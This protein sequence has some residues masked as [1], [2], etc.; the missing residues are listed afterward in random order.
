MQ[1]GGELSPRHRLNIL[2][3]ALIMNKNII[4]TTIAF[5][6]ALAGTSVCA[7]NPYV[8][9]WALTLPT[10]GPGWLG[11]TQEKKGLEAGILWGGGS[12]KPVSSI[13]VEGEQ[14]VITRVAV[15][16]RGPDKGKNHGNHHGHSFR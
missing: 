10:G 12:V 2:H 6:S 13:K 9:N 3:F 14:L 7:D 1:N 15:A 5:L 8:G 11:I 4:I 16:R